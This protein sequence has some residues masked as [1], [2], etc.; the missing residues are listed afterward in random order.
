MKKLAI[1]LA[2]MAAATAARADVVTAVS[3]SSGTQC[4]SVTVTSYTHTAGY[5]GTAMIPAG[6]LNATAPWTSRVVSIQNR[7]AT[8]ANAIDCGHW[9]D[10]STITAPTPATDLGWGIPGATNFSWTFPENQQ[11]YCT[12]EL[13]TAAII[14]DVCIT[15]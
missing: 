1:I 6:M 8:A 14:A 7:N 12:G 13:T 3:L 10:V 2:L 15:Q 11:W 5:S 9:V 4:F